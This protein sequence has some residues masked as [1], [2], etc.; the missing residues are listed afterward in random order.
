M[1]NDLEHVDVEVDAV[2]LERVADRCGV[3]EELLDG[4]AVLGHGS[5]DALSVVCEEAAIGGG[6]LV[7]GCRLC[8]ERVYLDLRNFCVRDKF[9][10]AK[11]FLLDAFL[12]CSDSL[13]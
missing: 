2:A 12:L 6:N 3:G 7:R 5:C 8:Q 1:D 11:L 9:P 4:L 13:S 10:H